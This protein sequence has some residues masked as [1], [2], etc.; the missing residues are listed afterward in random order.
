MMTG[1]G[2]KRGK[3]YKGKIARED[4]WR[5]TIRSMMEAGKQMVKLHFKPYFCVHKKKKGE[6]YCT[7]KGDLGGG[8]QKRKRM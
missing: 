8:D 7:K 4:R 2:N 1:A 6:K 3:E 5:K